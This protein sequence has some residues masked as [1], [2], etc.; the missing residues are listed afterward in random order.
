M[1][2]IFALLLISIVLI[3][4]ET[5]SIYEHIDSIDGR[6]LKDRYIYLNGQRMR[7]IDD[8][9]VQRLLV[10]ENKMNR[11]VPFSQRKYSQSV[12]ETMNNKM[13]SFLV[14]A[15]CYSNVIEE[16]TAR[17]KTSAI[18]DKIAVPWESLLPGA[19]SS[20]ENKVRCFIDGIL[21]ATTE[22]ANRKLLYIG[23]FDKTN[24]IYELAVVPY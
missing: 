19:L 20:N 23:N 9:L 16:A 4:A 12:C 6:I 21:F 14:G 7:E 1:L 10:E 24:K 2:K 22:K 5:V 3:S 13:F 15:S 17:N 11:L 8:V 18:I